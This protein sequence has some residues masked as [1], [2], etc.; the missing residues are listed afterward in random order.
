VAASTTS[1]VVV[2]DTTSI[3]DRRA[4]VRAAEAA[5]PVWAVA[6]VVADRLAAAVAVLAAGVEEDEAVVAVVAA[7]ADVH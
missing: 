1:I 4:L 5:D 2:G 3:A 7:D 6:A